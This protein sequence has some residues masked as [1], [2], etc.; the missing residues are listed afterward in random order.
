MQLVQT[1][2]GVLHLWASELMPTRKTLVFINS[3]GTDFRIWD[4]VV[5]A[6]R[7]RFNIVLHDKA[8]HGL[9]ADPARPGKLGNYSEDLA[10]IL[11]HLGL[12]KVILCGISAGGLI[13]QDFCRKRPDAVQGLILSN[14]GLRIGT[15]KSWDAR[16]SAIEAG[17]ISAIAD[18]ILQ[19]W[20][21]PAFRE[22]KNEYQLYRNMLVRTSVQGYLAC[23][24]AVRDANCTDDAANIS[25]PVL[26]IAGEHDLSTPPELVKDLASQIPSARFELL[27]GVAHLPCI[28]SPEIYTKLISNFVETI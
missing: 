12:S 17:G 25:V 11:Q 20:F 3:L 8:G 1:P 23:C 28:E 27:K 2:T 13:A 15:A 22:Q 24:E 4:G 14:T 21:A 19:R 9:S 18:A 6:L 26:C 10:A 5:A 7:G 16:I